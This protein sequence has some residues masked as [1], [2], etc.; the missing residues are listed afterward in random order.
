M[1]VLGEV[2]ITHAKLFLHEGS[3]ETADRDMFRQ[4]LMGKAFFTLYKYA[5]TQMLLFMSCSSFGYHHKCKQI[6]RH[7][8]SGRVLDSS[9][10]PHK[11]VHTNTEGHSIFSASMP[12]LLDPGTCACLCAHTYTRTHTDTKT[13][14]QTHVSL[15]R[16]LWLLDKWHGVHIL[17]AAWRR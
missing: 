16:K 12:M 10:T 7:I 4:L 13:N 5:H 3:R 9:V 6:N 11:H 15:I 14:M 1:I 17:P 8:R 2:K